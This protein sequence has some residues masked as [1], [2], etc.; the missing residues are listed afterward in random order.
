MKANT[1]LS[2]S[3]ATSTVKIMQVIHSAHCYFLYTQHSNY[4]S[5]GSIWNGLEQTQSLSVSGNWKVKKSSL[6]SEVEV[7]LAL[8]TV[9]VPWVLSVIDSNRGTIPLWLSVNLIR[10]SLVI[11]SGC[12]S[13]LIK[14]SIII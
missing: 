11:Y 1:E 4:C 14:S 5:K 8:L 2:I 7:S 6:R 3:S 13:Q 12:T 10:Q 9:F